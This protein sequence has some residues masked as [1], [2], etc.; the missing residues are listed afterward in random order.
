MPREEKVEAKL[1]QLLA[2]SLK[3]LIDTD[4][5]M[6]NFKRKYTGKVDRT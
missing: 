5:S 2:L 6:E 3:E 4:L 1:R